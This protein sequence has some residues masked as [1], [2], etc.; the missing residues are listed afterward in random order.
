MEQKVMGA[1]TAVIL[2]VVIIM[3]CILIYV[4]NMHIIALRIQDSKLSGG[5]VSVMD[6]LRASDLELRG[7]GE[8]TRESVRHQT[9]SAFS[10]FM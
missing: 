7:E 9:I 4:P 1:F 3:S 10:F 2:A 6:M 8:E 5:R